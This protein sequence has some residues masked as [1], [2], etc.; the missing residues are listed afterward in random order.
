MWRSSLRGLEGKSVLIT[1]GCGDIG[2]AVAERFLQAGA[3]VVIADLTPNE[4]G[5]TLANSLHP[6]NALYVSCDVRDRRSV[7]QA[8]AFVVSK[9]GRM[10]VA[11]SNAGAVTNAPIL[12]ITEEGWLDT[13]S[14]N[15]TGSLHV[16][17]AAA[18]AM[19]QNAPLASG[20]RGAILFTGSWV[21]RM[22][23]PQGGGYCAS[24]GGQEMLMKVMAQ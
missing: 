3:N 13:L 7:E 24:K 16:G 14:V 4:A 6:S 15:L 10:D 19:M 17:Q 5:A 22:P 20:R 1:G 21:Q 2:R 23:W 11:I 8:V 9:L 12:E 18:R